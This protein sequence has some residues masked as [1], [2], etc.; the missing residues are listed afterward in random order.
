[1]QLTSAAG[2]SLE[3]MGIAE[4]GYFIARWLSETTPERKLGHGMILRS[5]F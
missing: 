4:L 1:M 5:D 3:I 2:G